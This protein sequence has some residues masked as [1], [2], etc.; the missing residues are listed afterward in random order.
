MLNFPNVKHVSPLPEQ[1]I[2]IQYENGE[3][4]IFDVSIYQREL[5]RTACQSR[6][7]CNRPSG[8]RYGHVERWTGHSPS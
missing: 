1:R 4:K 2:E 8:R 7:I 5:V 6:Y 3:T